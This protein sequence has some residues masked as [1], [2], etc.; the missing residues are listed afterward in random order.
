V[1][2]PDDEVTYSTPDRGPIA[3]G[4]ACPDVNVYKIY[5]PGYRADGNQVMDF[6]D[7]GV[8]VRRDWWW[9]GYD[10][11]SARTGEATLNII[12]N[13]DLRIA[14]E[15]TGGYNLAWV[16][17]DKC[18]SVINIEGN[19]NGE[20]NIVVR[21]Q[22]RPQWLDG[23]VTTVNMSAGEFRCGAVETYFYASLIVNI[24]GGTFHCD[25]TLPHNSSDGR[26]GGR[27]VYTGS[28]E[29][30][31]ADPTIPWFEL[32]MTGGL[33]KIDTLFEPARAADA[34]SRIYLDA[35]VIECDEFGIGSYT[36]TD[37]KWLGW[38]T[39]D[40]L[41]DVND[42]ELRIGG[43]VISQIEEYVEAEK[44]TAYSGAVPVSISYNG[45]SNQTIVK[46]LIVHK[47]AWD[48]SPEPG[49]QDICP[50]VV[51]SWQPGDY[52]VDHN[53]Y[54]GTSLSDVNESATPV[55]IHV[56]PNSWDPPGELVLNT[57]Y[58]WR[59][60]GVNDANVESPWVGD[61]W[62][63]TTNDGN[64]FDP[65]PTDN[66][67]MAPVDT[68]LSWMPA[69]IVTSQDLYFGTDYEDVRDATTASDPNNVYIGPLGA[70]DDEYDPG[71]LAYYTWYY[72]RVDS[73][74]GGQVQHG[75]VWGFRTQSFIV[76][77]HLLVWYKFDDEDAPGGIG[78]DYSGHEAPINVGTNNWDPNDGFEG[79]SLL[80][81]NNYGENIPGEALDPI[82]S[83]ITVSVWV[84]GLPS[85]PSG[86][87][88]PVFDAGDESEGFLEGEF[89][90]TG[91]IPSGD[92]DVCWRAGND[93][94]DVLIW[95]GATPEAWKGDWHHFAFVKDEIT[96]F[97]GIYFDS[98]LVDSNGTVD[99][100]LP[101]VKFKGSGKGFKIG[102]YTDHKDDYRG[103]VD[104]F[105]VYDYALSVKEIQ[106][107]FRGGDL[108]LAWGPDPF[109][110]QT[111]VPRD[112][113]PNW[114]AGDFAD[115]HDVYF[116]TDW[117]D[118]NDAD[119]VSGAY[120]GPQNIDANAYDPGGLD[121]TATY[122]WRIDE[123]NDANGDTWKGAVW[124]F[125]VADFLIVDD[126]ESYNAVSGSGNE[127]YDTWDD[128]FNNWT[129]SQLA[130]EY[131]DNATILGGKQTMKFQYDNAIG[132]YKYSEIDANTTGP[133]P[134]N[135]DIG[136]DWT[137]A[138]VKALTVFFHGHAGNDTT[139]Q[140]YVALEDGSSHIGVAEYGDLGENM[141]D[142]AVADWQQWDIPLSAFSGAGVILT[143]VAKVRL[144][145]GDRVS[146]VVGGSGI[147]YFDDIRL[148]LPKCVPWLLKPAA[149][150][151]SNCIV[152]FEDV[153][154]MAEDW[155][156][157]DEQFD[158][159]QA[160]DYDKRVGWWTLDNTPWDDSGNFF[161]GTVEGDYAWVA[162]QIGIGAIE[163]KGNGSRVLVPHHALLSPQDEVSVC[164]WIN[165]S[166]TPGYSARVL[167]KG[168]DAGDRESYA[169]QVTNDDM[170]S[171]IVRDVNTTLYGAGSATQLRHD[172][173]THI[174]A[175]YD[176]D[177][178]KCYLNAELSD[179]ETPGPLSILVDTNDLAIG[180]RADDTNRAF[181][182]MIDDV[183]IYEYALSQPEIVHVATEGSGYMPLTAA[184]NLYNEESQGERAVNLR[185]FGVIAN[186]WLEE[187]L[188][189]E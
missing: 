156:R 12:G 115:G 123:V 132:F 128:G 6:I 74:D 142:I 183:Q 40:F 179:S 95:E 43:N 18:R 48:P 169:L 25:S 127:I 125:T 46:A 62:V 149:D 173:W 55:D 135:L 143:D 110:G 133:Q 34:H 130:L 161:D 129:G 94:N 98:R 108:N 69:C 35:G 56:G 163:L 20:P 24:S 49:A 99:S 186:S 73:I 21:G 104:D 159:V 86:H 44:I 13:T 84:N 158:T 171:F 30:G 101:S 150:L 137:E 67:L 140:M 136:T 162:G 14:S 175:T 141:A 182:G 66:L 27:F 109:N 47:Q 3:D 23:T 70:G 134:G 188:W 114:N 37:N 83:A 178:A 167:A 119:T 26:P 42:G 176:G 10:H 93:S 7:I 33:L 22:I 153:G 1:P 111:D 120:K 131:G 38:E 54:F 107:L 160:P 117:D 63:F 29:T 139:E 174:A 36:P 187:A 80:C 168:A 72:W 112:A 82:G 58:Y 146:P 96:D 184:S 4:G 189:P 85:Q 8:N 75:D 157:M 78:H 77:P 144:G 64:A 2:G 122:Y 28:T 60:D 31:T 76:D 148:Y 116:G 17:R 121:L 180:N 105:R 81:N 11:A 39:I 41:M 172:E 15:G 16:T 59:V 97:M 126:M 53:V 32:N 61:V 9:D 51:L 100:T 165:Y 118:V 145:F 68:K 138:G 19:G 52:V 57:T 65:G 106:A 102:A 166:T 92:S 147:V 154:I 88:Q 181:I 185:D 151:S 79:G 50:G 164:A 89:K 5:G 113:I 177:V 45:I 87:D 124:R 91:L 170:A 71:G 103:K 155:L 152:D 90:V